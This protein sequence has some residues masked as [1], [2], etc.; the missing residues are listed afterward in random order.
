MTE[1]LT[2]FA[3]VGAIIAVGFLSNA[4]FKKTGFPDTLFLMLISII[5]GPLLGVFLREEM[6][7]F[8]PFLTTLTLIMILFEGGLNMEIYKVL[9]QSI[10]A[11]ILGVLYVLAA[12][13]FVTLFGY[14]VL[15]LGWLE[16]LL[17]GPMTAAANVH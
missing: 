3:V 5:L 17:L 14:F 6:L 9:S 12:M 7:P 11:T 13:A 4:L 16:A 8:T 10:R 15:G 2:I 1:A